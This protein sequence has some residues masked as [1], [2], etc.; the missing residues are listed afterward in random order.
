[1]LRRYPVR[2]TSLADQIWRDP[3]DG[4][5]VVYFTTYCGFCHAAR[6]L[7][8]GTGLPVNEV[9]VTR[10]QPARQALRDRTGSR[11]V[12]QIW[13]GGTY[14]GGYTDLVPYLQSIGIKK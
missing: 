6:R 1:M 7:L 2:M 11:T 13:H 3:D 14:V 10:D 12:P 5:F 8:N 9:D 4:E